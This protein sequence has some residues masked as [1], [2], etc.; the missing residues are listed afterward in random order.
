MTLMDELLSQPT[1]CLHRT[2]F[3]PQRSKPT[4]AKKLL[5]KLLHVQFCSQYIQQEVIC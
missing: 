5:I 1:A 2:V 3:R 4:E